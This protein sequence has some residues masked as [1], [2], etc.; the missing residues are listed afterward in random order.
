MGF[1]PHQ[2]DFF[3]N[4]VQKVSFIMTKKTTGFRP[5]QGI[6]FLILCKIHGKTGMAR[7]TVSVP[8]RRLFF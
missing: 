4:N 3:F 7:G 5:H 6:I 8:I 1:R 2:G